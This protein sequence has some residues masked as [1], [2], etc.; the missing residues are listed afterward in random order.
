ME[1]CIMV[2]CDLHDKTMLL[3]IAADRGKPLVR[4]WGTDASARQAMVYLTEMGDLS[5]FANRQQVGAF[6]GLVPSSFETGKDDDRKGHI[7]HQGPSRVLGAI[8][9]HEGLAAQEALRAA[10]PA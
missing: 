3:K 5:R 1:K 4:G 7:T 2:G 9:W 10:V 6:L 8:L